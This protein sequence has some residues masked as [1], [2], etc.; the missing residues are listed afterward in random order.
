MTGC[1]EVVEPQSLIRPISI[2]VTAELAFAACF[3][4]TLP[5]A[6]CWLLSRLSEAG[7]RGAGVRA[8]L[9]H[10]VVQRFLLL[11]DDAT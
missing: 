6:T 5:A 11:L 9:C 4:A 1:C 10:R 2:T 7:N 8:H 3:P